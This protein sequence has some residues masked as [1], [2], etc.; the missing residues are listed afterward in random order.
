[1]VVIIEKKI[2]PDF[3]PRYVLQHSYVVCLEPPSTEGDQPPTLPTPSLSIVIKI[4]FIAIAIA[5]AIVMVF[6]IVMLIILR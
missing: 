6:K 2:I 1:M 4:F 5:I 3:L